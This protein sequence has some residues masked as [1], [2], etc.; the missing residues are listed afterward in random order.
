M[1]WST[2]AAQA[3]DAEPLAAVVLAATKH[4]GRWPADCSEQAE[5][6]WLVGF[7]DWTLQTIDQ[8]DP[9]NRL[10]VILD[11][12]GQVIGRL[13]VLRDG[14]TPIETATR[15]ELAGVQLLP[16][17]QRHGIGTAIVR[18]LQREAADA[19][20]ALDIGVEKDNPG[21]R[22]LYERLGCVLVDRDDREY[23]LRWSL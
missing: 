1:R 21:A 5:R 10:D 2:R 7:A 15:I 17:A 13:R 14:E 8:A 22:R 12:D 18:E 4:Q 19:R 20:C 11:E 23:K 3:A 16:A 6:E 9:N